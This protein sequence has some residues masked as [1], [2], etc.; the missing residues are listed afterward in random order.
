MPKPAAEI[1]LPGLTLNLSDSKPLYRQVYDGLRDMILSGQL[2]PGQRLPSTRTLADDFGVSRNTILQ[3]YEVLHSEGYV[4]GQT[5]S[6]TYISRNLPEGLTRPE[7]SS[8][9]TAR[10]RPEAT[11]RLSRRGQTIAE[12][13][14]HATS[15]GSVRPLEPGVPALDAFPRQIWTRLVGNAIARNYLGY[16]DPAGFRPLREEIASH[17]RS[18]RAVTCE[19]QQVV[20]V[21]GSQQALDIAARILL[22][23]GDDVWVEDPGYPGAR[24]A[25]SGAGANL[26]HVPV[27]SDGLVVEIGV[28]MSPDAH[29]AYV[30]PSHQYPTGA[31]MSLA[32]RFELLKWASRAG[33]WVLEDDYDSEYRYTGRPLASLQGLDFENRVIYIGTFSKVLFPALRLGYVI[34]PPE[35]VDP[36]ISA[37]MLTDLNSSIVEQATLARFFADGHFARH[38]RRMRVLYQQRQACLIAALQEDLREEISIN[39][40]DTGLHT[41]LWLPPDVN[42]GGVSGALGARGVFAAAVSAYS[43]TGGNQRGLVLGYAAFSEDVIRQSAQLIASVVNLHVAP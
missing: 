33:A 43:F 40:S 10:P 26:V 22:D 11:R 2:G 38:V 35:L 15:L 12:S 4:N 19:W 24:L 29:V 5:G 37:R 30:N 14:F 18:S 27:D 34:V 6:G 17:V 9:G 20:I 13:A 8:E 42:D 21:N 41:V 31:T 25:F 16:A 36:V 28:E 32:R 3:A 39:P 23:E 1:T 7:V